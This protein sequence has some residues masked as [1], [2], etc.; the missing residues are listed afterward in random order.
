MADI[1][2]IQVKDQYYKDENGNKLTKDYAFANQLVNEN[3]VVCIPMS[4]FYDAGDSHLGERFVRFAFCKDE[5]I[6][7]EAATRLQQKK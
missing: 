5:D 3:K 7:R 4:S 6:I 2:R 1:S